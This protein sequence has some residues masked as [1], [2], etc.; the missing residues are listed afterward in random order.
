MLPYSYS[1][2]VPKRV[3][4]SLLSITCAKDLQ[5]E[6]NVDLCTLWEATEQI[7]NHTKPTEMPLLHYC[8]Q[9]EYY[10]IIVWLISMIHPEQL[11][12]R[13]GIEGCI[14]LH[15]AYKRAWIT[16]KLPD[17]FFRRTGMD[18]YNSEKVASYVQLLLHRFP[19]GARYANAHGKL[20]LMLYLEHGF[21]FSSMSN[22]T[23]LP[24]Q[25]D[26]QCLIDASPQVLT[27]PDISTR[28]LPFMIPTIGK[29]DPYGNDHDGANYA[30]S[31]SY[32]LLRRYP[33]VI[34]MVALNVKSSDTISTSDTPE[35][36]RKMPG[37][38][39]HTTVGDDDKKSDTVNLQQKLMDLH[40]E[41]RKQKEEIEKQQ[42]LIYK[43]LNQVLSLGG[44]L[45]DDDDDV[46]GGSQR[47]DNGLSE[48]E[49]KG[50]KKEDTTI[51]GL[52]DQEQREETKI[53]DRAR[54]GSS[55][56]SFGNKDN[57]LDSNPS[58]SK[59]A[60]FS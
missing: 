13:D 50:R 20:P 11:K 46:A 28:L 58:K 44:S 12:G 57:R 41:N 53:L 7:L 60:K 5:L 30:I 54:P 21:R 56:K 23:Y 45:D 25:D 8:V 1:G 55:I 34:A 3:H 27:T 18:S 16:E 40:D 51:D 31:V 14:P 35:D 52:N 9:E 43:L 36:E 2:P 59:K 6:S 24:Q 33:S 39:A 22:K 4:N 38:K 37:R 17:E 10:P 15:Y 42:N 19:D 26:I 32:D 48:N 29:F 47:D 49:S